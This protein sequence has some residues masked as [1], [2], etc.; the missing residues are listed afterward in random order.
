MIL[1]NKR[2]L[3]WLSVMFVIA[4]ILSARA[5]CGD[6]PWPELKVKHSA[7]LE[8]LLAENGDL[9]EY[10]KTAKPEEF[11]SELAGALS[12]EN[13]TIRLRAGTYLLEK[14]PEDT[15]R[16]LPYVRETMKKLAEG[17]LAPLTYA[18]DEV[19]VY[20]RFLAQ[21]PE[22]QS[23]PVLIAVVEVPSLMSASGERVESSDGHPLSIFNGRPIY[24]E[25]GAAVLKCSGGEIGKMADGDRFAATKT[26]NAPPE[27]KPLVAFSI[28]VSSYRDGNVF[29]QGEPVFVTVGIRRT[30]NAQRGLPPDM[31]LRIGSAEFPWYKNLHVSLYSPEPL[32]TPTQVPVAPEPALP[33]QQPEAAVQEQEPAGKDLIPKRIL[34]KDARIA[35]LGPQPKKEEMKVNEV[36]MSLWA[37]DPQSSAA[38]PPGKYILQADLD[39]TSAAKANPDVSIVKCRS[40]EVAIVVS[41]P[42]TDQNRVDVLSAQA[43]YWER[44]A[45]YDNAIRL[46]EQISR[47][48]PDPVRQTN[49]H[50]SLGR[51]YELKGDLDTAI[52]EY[53][54]YVQRVRGANLPRTGKDD[55]YDHAEIIESTIKALE[56]KRANAATH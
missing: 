6:A 37:L 27:D 18:G 12:H 35:P 43:T 13:G 49:V 5:F 51:A 34:L 28:S 53:K 29:Y 41:A 16:V 15:A 55:T 9:T 24:S 52:E 22:R 56:Q 50:L 30:S 4:W 32:Q 48:D 39:T 54:T 1:A 7:E 8:K 47:L 25:V 17:K 40:N 14:K 26:Q 23:I 36:L 46:L 44:S 10:A 42:V 2:G 31:M 19:S 20:V 45:Q 11:L 33:S 3:T 21:Y 38:I